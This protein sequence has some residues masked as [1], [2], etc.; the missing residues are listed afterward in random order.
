MPHLSDL[1]NQATNLICFRQYRYN[2]RSL[3]N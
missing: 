2:I 3:F 1:T